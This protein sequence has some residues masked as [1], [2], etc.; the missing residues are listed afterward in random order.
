MEVE[1]DGTRGNSSERI[2]NGD[3]VL[4][5][6]LDAIEPDPTSFFCRLTFKIFSECFS[7]RKRREMFFQTRRRSMKPDR[8]R[9]GPLMRREEPLDRFLLPEHIQVMPD[10]RTP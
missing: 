10:A 4:S 7:T 1:V 5:S 9:F 8:T 2:R 6:S 3:G